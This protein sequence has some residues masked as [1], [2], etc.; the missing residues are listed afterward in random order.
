MR[1]CNCCTSFSFQ[2][3]AKSERFVRI[4]SEHLVRK[5]L[6][7]IGVIEPQKQREYKE[8]TKKK[9]NQNHPGDVTI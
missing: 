2:N 7:F 8:N 6:H 4:E 1:G 3:V 9:T 5:Y